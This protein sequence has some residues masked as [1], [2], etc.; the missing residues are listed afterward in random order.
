MNKELISNSYSIMSLEIRLKRLR[1][2]S[3]HRGCKETDLVLGHFADEA[4]DGL[5]P[6]MLDV[7]ERL[8][9]EDDANIWDW[10]IGKTT[11]PQTEYLPLL[12]L[13]KGYG[14]PST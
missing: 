7:Y 5:D 2:R 9:D 6:A 13:L 1:Y 4:L 3:A 14:L 10:L 8:L 12:T 11:P